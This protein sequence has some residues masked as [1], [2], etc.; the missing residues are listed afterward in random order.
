MCTLTIATI[1]INVYYNLMYDTCH[2]TQTYKSWKV[3][4]CDSSKHVKEVLYQYPVLTYIL[5]ITPEISVAFLP[6]S[7]IDR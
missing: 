3:P 7:C 4:I 2:Y 1:H 6:P 5:H